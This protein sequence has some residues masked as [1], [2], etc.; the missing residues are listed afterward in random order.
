MAMAVA[1]TAVPQYR[2][3]STDQERV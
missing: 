3:H 2:L 1:V